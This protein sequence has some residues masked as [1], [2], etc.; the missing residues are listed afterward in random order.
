MQRM[1]K[2]HR[3]FSQACQVLPHYLNQ[4]KPWN[5]MT[6]TC[7]KFLNSKSQVTLKHV[8]TFKFDSSIHDTV[9]FITYPSTN[10]L[11][12]DNIHSGTMEWIFRQLETKISWKSLL[13]ASFLS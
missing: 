7:S 10:M 13:K 8:S 2:T 1:C 5:W 12:M 9:N 6:Y 4:L 11:S 3:F